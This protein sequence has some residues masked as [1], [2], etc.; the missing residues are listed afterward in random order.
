[1]SDF[2]RDTIAGG[3]AGLFLVVIFS[4]FSGYGM[5]GAG[6]AILVVFLGSLITHEGYI[7]FG[8]LVALL[9]IW[10]VWAAKIYFQ[11]K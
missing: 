11:Q 6:T 5:R 8:L 1:M 3:L 2:I 7:A 4:F 10:A 9:I